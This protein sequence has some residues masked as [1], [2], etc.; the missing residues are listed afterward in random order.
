MIADPSYRLVLLDELNIVLRY[1]YLPLDEVIAALAGQAARPARHRHRPQRQA[2]ADRDRRPRHRDDAGEASVPRRRQGAGAGS[3][4][5]GGRRPGADAAGHRLRC[6]QIAA[7][8]R[9]RARVHPARPQGAAVQA[10]EHVEQRRGDRRWRR[11]RPR[12]GAAGAR[13]RRRAQRRHEPGAA[14]AAIGAAARSWWSAASVAGAVAARE[15]QR[16]DAGAAAARARAR[17]SRLAASADLVLV[18]GAGS[19]AEIN[20]RAGDIANM[21][22]AEAADVP[23]VLVGDIDRGGVIAAARRHA[24]AARR[25]AS[26]P[27]S[28]ATSSTSSAA[29]SRLFDGGA[30]RDRRAHR[31]RCFGVVPWF[32]AARDLPAED[33]MALDRPRAAP[34][35]RDGAADRIAVP[36]LPRIANFDDLD[37]LRAEPGGRARSGRAGHGRCRATRSGACCRA[38]RRRSPISPRCAREGWDIDILAHARQRRRRC[39]GICGGYQMLGRQHRRSRRASK[40]RRARAP[41]LGLLDI[42]TVLGGD[43]RLGRGRRHARSPAAQPVAGYEMHLGGTSGGRAGAADAASWRPRTTARVSADG[44]VA[45]CYLHGL[46]AGDDFRRAFLARLGGSGEPAS[47]TRRGSRRRSTRSPI[48][49]NAISTSRA[50]SRRRGRRALHGLHEMRRQPDAENE[51]GQEHARPAL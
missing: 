14:E 4:S 40:A 47:S 43:K 5:D 8:R 49:S 25:R 2:R 1:D 33:S 42:E 48:I 34:A 46:F 51:P 35:T 26:A 7:G 22:F 29:T 17:S 24:C 30:R 37:P 18:E 11:D 32:A 41:G 10:A 9:A 21:G 27:G 3:S 31:P 6:R 13:L 19:P 12:P 36:L 44:R 23:V 39:S 38:R 15:Y 20:L 45:G 50:C 16:A 28:M